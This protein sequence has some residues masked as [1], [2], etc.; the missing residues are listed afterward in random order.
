MFRHSSHAFDLVGLATSSTLGVSGLVGVVAQIQPPQQGGPDWITLQL[1]LAISSLVTAIIFVHRLLMKAKEETILK[2][3]GGHLAVLASKDET[4]RLLTDDRA[5]QEVEAAEL[6]MAVRDA[7]KEKEQFVLQVL[8]QA[9]KA[10][11]TASAGST[12]VDLH[13]TLHEAAT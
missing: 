8:S 1:V 2:L 12:T 9:Q 13:G 3:E 11:A 7:L 6:R 4:I 10:V 5:R